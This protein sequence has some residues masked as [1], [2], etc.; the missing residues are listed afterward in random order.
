[1][2]TRAETYIRLTAESIL[3]HMGVFLSEDRLR[4]QLEARDSFYSR[5]IPLPTRITF[6]S[7][8]SG[9][10][11]DIRIYAQERMVEY[12]LSDEAAEITPLKSKHKKKAS[13]SRDEDEDDEEEYDEESDEEDEND[14]EDEDED[15]E[16]SWED[17]GDGTGGTLKEQLE[18]QRLNLIQL[19][20][21]LVELQEK[22]YQL[23]SDTFSFQRKQAREWEQ[24]SK[25][26][27]EDLT[28]IFKKCRPDLPEQWTD[29]LLEIMQTQVTLVPISDALLQT[30]ALDKT[31]GL[32][33]KAVLQASIETKI[34]E[35]GQPQNPCILSVLE[36]AQAIEEILVAF[37]NTAE[38]ERNE[39]LL[40]RIHEEDEAFSQM[41]Q[42]LLVL[43][44]T[45][46]ALLEQVKKDAF[47]PSPETALNNKE[48][49]VH[50]T[51]ET[52]ISHSHIR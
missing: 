25:K 38:D 22:H 17:E 5:L 40:P 20:D 26:Q 36:E 46:V 6:N 47:L 12:L 29:F 51:H 27:A 45:I 30:Y 16:E 28:A 43:R 19:G 39:E 33:K 42:D 41:R 10:C 44:D 1:M 7:L 32:L 31:G 8:L 14:E 4:A 21:A 34:L 23:M 11:A 50:L 37:Q 15:D 18:A 2:A 24:L 52:L 35:E 3:D 49:D 13:R 48:M 9:Q